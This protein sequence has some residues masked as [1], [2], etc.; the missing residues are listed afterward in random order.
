MIRKEVVGA[1]LMAVTMTAF[2]ADW[3]RVGG[4]GIV[5][6]TADPSSIV[7]SGDIAK[8]WTAT[9]YAAPTM[10]HGYAVPISRLVAHRI[11]NCAGKSVAIG[12]TRVYDAS[13][14]QVDKSPGEPTR[15]DDIAPGTV[16]ETIIDG[17][18]APK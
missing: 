15:F 2:G 7:R 6:V 18:C 11:Y 16:D 17:A 4:N 14:Q 10:L 1:A 9:T 12:E 13:N 8:V 3:V 5:T